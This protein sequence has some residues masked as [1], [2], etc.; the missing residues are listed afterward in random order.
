MRKYKK[1]IVAIS[2]IILFFVTGFSGIVSSVNIS[3]P[4]EDETLEINDDEVVWITSY[5]YSQY[6][7]IKGYHLDLDVCGDSSKPWWGNLVL[8][9]RKSDYDTWH[10]GSHRAACP[11][12]VRETLDYSEAGTYR[13]TFKLQLGESGEVYYS[14]PKTITVSIRDSKNL[15]NFDPIFSELINRFLHIFNLPFYL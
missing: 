8:N 1:K 4:S 10:Q 5:G 7:D 9:Y 12:C 15:D 14:E 2:I 13:I 6:Y 3:K 11:G